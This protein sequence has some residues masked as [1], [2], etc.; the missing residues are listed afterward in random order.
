[1]DNKHNDNK[2]AETL[3]LQLVHVIRATV[4]NWRSAVQVG[5]LK[6]TGQDLQQCY[7]IYLNLEEFDDK[8][9]LPL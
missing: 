7:Q 5:V 1:M 8:E 4:L 3:E 6:S 2:Q 9:I